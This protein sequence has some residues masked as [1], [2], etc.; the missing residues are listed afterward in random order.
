MTVKIISKDELVVAEDVL[1]V[2]ATSE[3]L[4]MESDV[5]TDFINIR[6]A[7][8]LA[9][10][11][12][13]PAEKAYKKAEKALGVAADEL[14]TPA[15]SVTLTQ[16]GKSVLMGPKG[17]KTEVTDKETIKVIL[18]EETSDAIATYGIGDLRKY[19]TEAQ[20]NSVTAQI[21]ANKRKI[22]VLQ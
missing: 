10:S 12:F 8:L 21:H 18:G 6:Y 11:D 15:S 1:V 9:K 22:T 16:D 5:V 20:F 19:L 17:V 14:V 3:E 13:E 4:V 7:Y 2:D